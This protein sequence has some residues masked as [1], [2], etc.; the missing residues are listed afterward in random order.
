MRT[1]TSNLIALLTVCWFCGCSQSPDVA[2][3]FSLKEHNGNVVWNTTGLCLVFEGVRNSMLG[4]AGEMVIYSNRGGSGGGG[5]IP[6]E[7]NVWSDSYNEATGINTVTFQNHQ[8]QVKQRGTS[9]VVDNTEFVLSGKPKQT[10]VIPLRGE[11]AMRDFRAS[12]APGTP[13]GQLPVDQLEPV[14]AR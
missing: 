4:A 1:T 11:P 2:W 9:V 12:D 14:T 13:L 7:T 10:I 3:K 8:V 5:G 6:G